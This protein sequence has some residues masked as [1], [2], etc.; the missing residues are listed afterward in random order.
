[1]GN[2]INR[3]FSHMNGDQSAKQNQYSR[4]EGEVIIDNVNDKKKRNNKVAGEYIDF[5]EVK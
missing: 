2:F 3:N 1:M 5:E 4:R